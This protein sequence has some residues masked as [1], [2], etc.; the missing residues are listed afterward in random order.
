MVR[1]KVKDFRMDWLSDKPSC[2]P[3]NQ[4][5]LEKRR[6]L[7]D[8]I[9][10]MQLYNTLSNDEK[11]EIHLRVKGSKRSVETFKFGRSA[12]AKANVLTA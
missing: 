2:R 9:Q 7:Q 8:Q 11:Q 12:L 1:K 6:Q 10:R 3:P 5:E 4:S